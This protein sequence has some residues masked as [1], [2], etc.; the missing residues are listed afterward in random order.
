PLHLTFTSDSPAIPL[1]PTAVAA[2]PDMGIIVHLLGEHRAV[3]TNFLHVTPNPA[4]I[5]W[6]GG[7][8]NYPDVV[9]AAADEAE[10][11]AFAT[12]YAG[13]AHDP[14][15]LPVAEAVVAR[16]AEAQ[17]LADV[18]N[19]V[20]LWGIDADWQ[21]VLRG[22]IA[23]DGQF[24]P[25]D[26]LGCPDCWDL[27]EVAV[28][29]GALAARV[30]TE[31]N[32]PREQIVALYQANDYLT[33]LYTRM[34]AADMDRDPIFAFNPD[35]DDVDRTRQAVRHVGCDGEGNLD[36]DNSVIALP[37]GQQVQLVAGQM[38]GV[39]QRQAGETIRGAETQAAALTERTFAAGQSEVVGELANPANAPLPG[40]PSGGGDGCGCDAT[41]GGS[42][43]LLM[44]LF[45]APLGLSPRRRRR[46]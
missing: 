46:R 15:L 10:G 39:I 18:G 9:A 22:V 26:V 17:S 8:R 40:A 23:T 27:S 34:S 32:A 1:R 25:D 35:L 3:P 12:D 7:G 37:D 4:A 41:E 29:G 44:L 45:L 2:E 14:V 21:R 33:R 19:E 30:R 6:I 5:D 28:D 38:P 31:I 24:T 43:P 11:Q 13:R 42:A 20:D 16:L 36:F